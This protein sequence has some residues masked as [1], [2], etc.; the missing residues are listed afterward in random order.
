MKKVLLILAA[1]SGSVALAV[2]MPAAKSGADQAAAKV[3]EKVVVEQPPLHRHPTLL[4]MLR[5]SNVIRRNAG[6]RAQRIN[7]ALTKAAQ[8]HANYMAATGDFSHYTNGGYQYRAQKYGFKGGVRENI[9][10]GFGTVDATFNTWQASGGHYASIV[11][12]TTE[13]GF[14]YAIS[15][16]GG[17]Y[18]VGVYG[19]PAEGDAAGE[20]EG[21]AE[22]EAARLKAEAEK[23]TADGKT[24]VA[25][26]E[27]KAEPAP[28]AETAPKTEKPA[29]QTPAAA[30]K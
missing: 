15:P 10:A 17:T 23:A 9:A 3:A 28:K 19:S 5:R 8:D 26:P 6:L 14:G 4:S 25:K 21:H 13:A 12:G 22:A 1:F 18:W 27:V 7:P 29:E 11:S 16:N 30:G 2:D 24:T 20:E